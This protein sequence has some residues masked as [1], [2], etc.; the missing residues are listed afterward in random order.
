MNI[1]I[2]QGS[3]I[4]N[5]NLENINNYDTLANLKTVKIHKKQQ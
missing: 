5:S 4:H 1:L 2:G 3:Y